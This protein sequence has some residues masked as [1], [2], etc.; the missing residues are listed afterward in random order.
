MSTSTA[1][2]EEMRA[3]YHYS[4]PRWYATLRGVRSVRVGDEDAEQVAREDASAY[5][6][7][8]RCSVSLIHMYGVSIRSV[9]TFPTVSQI[10]TGMSERRG[11][12]SSAFRK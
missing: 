4:C 7:S 9:K 1:S 10:S 5:T 12:V 2:A 11:F 8:D 6:G 3:M